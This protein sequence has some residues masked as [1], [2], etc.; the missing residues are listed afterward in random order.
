MTLLM[1]M[2]GEPVVIVMGPTD[3]LFL[4]D[5]LTST[6]APDQNSVGPLSGVRSTSGMWT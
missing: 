3:Q 2:C 1:A 4:S 5:H 6:A